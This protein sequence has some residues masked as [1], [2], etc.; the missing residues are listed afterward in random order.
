MY[1][2]LNF[3]IFLPKV[4]KHKKTTWKFKGRSR[5]HDKHIFSK[6]STI[7]Q[8]SRSRMLAKVWVFDA[9]LKVITFHSGLIGT[10][11]EWRRIRWVQSTKPAL[12]DGA[13][14]VVVRGLIH[15]EVSTRVRQREELNWGW[16]LK[17]SDQQ[18]FSNKSR[19]ESTLIRKD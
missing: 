13:H 14:L 7:F 2:F 11:L 10:F 3:K 15:Y 16:Q 6:L 12:L 18:I 4:C 1:Q 5:W 9:I 19:P 8:S 17:L